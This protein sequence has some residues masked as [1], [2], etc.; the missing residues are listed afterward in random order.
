MA[1]DARDVAVRG[2]LPCVVIG[3]HVVACLAELGLGADLN[4][5]EAHGKDDQGD[6]K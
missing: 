4:A 1:V 6:D 3:L 2:G 5:D